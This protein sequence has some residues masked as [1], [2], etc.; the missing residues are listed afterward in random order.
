MAI[1]LHTFDSVCASPALGRYTGRVAPRGG[2]REG[3]AESG[4]REQVRAGG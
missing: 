4:K 1:V 3:E 2:G